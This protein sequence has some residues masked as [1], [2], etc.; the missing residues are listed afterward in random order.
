VPRRL[1]DVGEHEWINLLSRRLG[2][3]SVAGVLIGPGDDAAVV[4]IGGA[5]ALLTTDTLVE[6]VHFRDGW[7]APAALGRRAFRVNA[8][9]I[10]AMG[11]RPISALVALEVQPTMA[12]NRL[13]AIM[14]GFVSDA[15][16]HGVALVGGN[17]T[18]GP[19]FAIT[20]SMTG[21]ASARVVR[22]RG[23]RAGDQVFVTGSLGAMGLAVRG[24]LAGRRTE[25]PTVPYRVDAAV[26][27]A[28]VASAMIDVSDGLVQDLGHVC[29]ASRVAA[30]IEA[31]RVPVA[32]AC[33]RAL[34]AGA[35]AFAATAGEDYELC[36]TVPP[37]RLPALD[38][39]RRRLRCRVT[40]IGTIEAGR[41][42]VRMV[43]AR[44]RPL[45]LRHRGF[46]H[47]RAR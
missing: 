12:V 26:A 45:V 32:P 37:R 21:I 23:A 9:D 42:I 22:R 19:H 5:V 4:R 43:D 13:D 34:G 2:G 27:L 47:L 8:S 39:L 41:P 11:G 17:V 38:R 29:R 1:R 35:A 3:R 10:A 15:R 16:R 46:D 28:A 18:R 24:R 7:L 40:R 44:G 20:V 25:L 36:F 31:G 30:R 14:R 6:G 33:R